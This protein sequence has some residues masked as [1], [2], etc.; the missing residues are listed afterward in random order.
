MVLLATGP[1]ASGPAGLEV[2]PANETG[3]SPLNSVLINELDADQSGVDM[4]EFIELLAPAQGWDLSAWVVVLYNGA[5]PDDEAYDA[6]AL[7]GQLAGEDGLFVLGS[8]GVESVDLVAFSS[9]G[10]QNGP[11]AVA[12]WHAPGLKASDFLGTNPST[13][14][15]GAR[16]ADALVHSTGDAPDQALLDALTPGAL[17]R[18]ESAGLGPSERSLQ[19]RPD[20]GAPFDTASFIP[21]APSPGRRNGTLHHVAI[22]AIQGPGHRSPYEGSFVADVEGVVT[23]V[24]DDRFHLQ[25]L[26]GSEDEDPHTS[27]ALLVLPGTADQPEVGDHILLSGWVEEHSPGG[28]PGNLSTT[29]LILLGEWVLVDSGLVL[30][31]P[32]V[33]GE[34]GHSL[35]RQIID[36]D[37]RGGQVSNTA[38]LFD[39]EQDG[40]DSF[41][42]LEG[43]RV[44]VREAYAIG[45]TTSFGEL[46]VLA[47]GGR[48]ATGLSVRGALLRSA[49]DANPERI[50]VDDELT[51]TPQAE[52]GDRFSSPLVGVLDY[53]FGNPKLLLTETAQVVPGSRPAEHL[54]NTAGLRVASLNVQNLSPQSS[55]ERIAE[56]AKT[57]VFGL[58][59]PDLV[60]LQ[61]VQDGSGPLN[62][63]VVS[64]LPSLMLLQGAIRSLG[65][66]RYIAVE[67]A[68]LDG[69]DGGQPGGNIRVAFLYRADS[70]LRL[71]ARA[72]GD[73]TTPTLVQVGADGSPQLAPSPGRI[74]P[75]DPAWLNSRKP[76]TA[77][78]EWRGQA[79]FI[80]NVHLSSKLGDTP[81]F[82]AWQPPVLASEAKRLPQ[83][84]V[85]RDFVAK[86]LAADPQAAVLVLGDCNDFEW[87]PAL[88]EF[89]AGGLLHNLTDGVPQGERGSYIYQG[90][91]QTLDHALASSALLPALLDYRIVHRHAGRLEAPSDHDPLLLDLSPTDLPN[92]LR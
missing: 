62:D 29:R 5:A 63:G 35:P 89:Q 61:E 65:G 71:V 58:N 8:T 20:G 56:L 72:G 28:S 16:L 9:N 70:D 82:G 15:A 31:A 77:E 75:E 25:A 57:L 92:G 90:N 14:P 18:D 4:L 39:P 51:P 87:S 41:E 76:L 74:A 86:I 67:I 81:L 66:P 46:P 40:L 23:A 6:I 13:P 19:R 1:L 49:E 21:S 36:N 48:L 2:R 59:A 26:P 45:A 64:G 30:P 52:L 60:A 27:E 7:T 37:T 33:L 47:D 69:M 85:V 12:L 42:S 34:G 44:Q 32:V 73:A 78:F 38:T 10:I 84:R 79:L 22:H 83:A 80:V 24:R 43:M 68:P 55:G 54:S 50:L 3:A 91:T 53:S 17:M 88:A 11:D